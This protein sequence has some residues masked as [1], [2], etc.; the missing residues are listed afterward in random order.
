MESEEVDNYANIDGESDNMSETDEASDS[1]VDF[2]EGYPHNYI[3]WSGLSEDILKRL[4]SNDRD[5]YALDVEFGGDGLGDERFDWGREGRSITENTRLMS[6]CTTDYGIHL[7]PEDRLAR[8]NNC[9]AFYRAVSLNRS[10]VHLRLVGCPFDIGEMFTILSPLLGNLRSLEI[11]LNLDMDPDKRIADILSSALLSKSKIGKLRKFEFWSGAGRLDD[12]SAANLVAALK[13]HTNLMELTTDFWCAELG[14]LLQNPASRIKKVKIGHLD[15]GGANDLGCYLKVANKTLK[16]L[17]LTGN[18][19]ITRR[20]WVSLAWGVGGPNSSLEV[21]HLM[22]NNID[23]ETAALL[24]NGL[25]SNKKLVDLTLQHTTVS[26]EG[27]QIFFDVWTNS[28]SSLEKLNISENSIGCDSMIG[29]M[30]KGV[31]HMRSLKT[32]ALY[33]NPLV[34]PA[35]W[36]TLAS[37]LQYPTKIQELHITG[38][39]HN[40]NDEVIMTLG[41]ALANNKT[42]QKLQIG[43]C[44]HITARA[45]DVLSTLLC[46]KS[47]IE[48]IYSSNHTLQSITWGNYTNFPSPPVL[49]LLAMNEDEDK[50]EVARQKI[51]RYGDINMEEFVD[52]KLW[53]LPHVIAWIGKD[54]GGLAEMRLLYQLVKSVPFLFDFHDVKAKAK[55]RMGGKRKRVILEDSEEE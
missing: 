29:H 36:L 35:G 7:H 3:S 12:E 42:L 27:W 44:G 30:V 55:Q 47:S 24:A 34:T 33:N 52:M 11:E 8:E 4:R 19:N 32:L 2:Y 13:T 49:F 22:G 41:N 18:R 21:I 5:I 28:K 37:L 23:N 53:V 15:D 10:I 16:T 50:V 51:L 45:W 38:N 9:R 25:S 43:D 40:I 6:L 54:F 46:N 31:Y 26:P 48:S 20:G 14:R 1:D 17:T 39:G